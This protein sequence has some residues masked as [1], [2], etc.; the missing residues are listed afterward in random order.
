MYPK[1]LKAW[2]KRNKDNL[3]KIFDN[4]YQLVLQKMAEA[5]REDLPVLQEFVR[6]L[7]KWMLDLTNIEKKRGRKPKK[8]N[9][10]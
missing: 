6:Y 1:Y 4:D 8:D 9:F 10:I 2:I 3:R 7:K 5:P